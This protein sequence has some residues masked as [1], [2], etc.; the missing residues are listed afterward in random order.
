MSCEPATSAARVRRA[1]ACGATSRS[2]RARCTASRWYFSTAPPPRSGRRSV[3]EAV[4]DYETDSP[5]QRA[6]RRAPLSQEATEA[7]FERARERVRALRQRRLDARNHLH[8]RHHRSRSTWWRSPMRARASTPATRSCITGA[9][10]SRQH[11]ALAAGVRAD[12]RSAQGRAH[13]PPRRVDVRRVSLH[14]LDERTRIVAVRARVQCARHGAA[15]QARSSRLA[16]A[17]GAV[18][19]IDGAQ[20][21][22]HQRVDVRSARLRL[23]RVLGAQDLRPDRHR[24]AVR[25]RGAAR[26]HAA[27]ARRRRHDPHRD[28]REDAPTTSCPASSKPARRT[29]PA[30]SA[31][32]P[33]STTSS[34]SASSASHA[35]EQRLLALATDE[36]ASGC[37][38]STIIGTAA[39]Q[40]RGHLLHDRRHPSA[41][42][43]H[44]P[45]RRRRGGAHRAPLR[46]AGHGLL[47]RA[48]HGARLVRAVYNTRVGHRRAGRRA[49]QGARGVRLMDLKDLYR[50]VILD[51][52]KQPAQLRPARSGRLRTPT[53][54]IRCA[55][56]ACT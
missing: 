43:R 34:R 21:V 56:T 33:P 22:P 29:S 9:R 15:G 41:R 3:I 28:L 19:L 39:R 10:A 7:M 1:S 12:R 2:S 38:A 45:R 48:R 24:R 40:G 51:H 25:A 49:G 27:V 53:A 37:R 52:N 6:S 8:A 11:R 55:A 44:H 20:A 17:R 4:D 23:L 16:H 32:R 31:W 14:A 13:R 42:S 35:H 36:A 26:G 5:C 46:H 50:D 18:V 30:R 47:R 54:T